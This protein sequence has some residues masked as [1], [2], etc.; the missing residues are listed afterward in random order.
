M[1]TRYI[2]LVAAAAEVKV[3]EANSKRVT[4][5]MWC[6]QADGAYMSDTAGGTSTNGILIFPYFPFE[7]RKAW[8]DDPTKAWY[9]YC[10]INN[11]VFIYEDIE[12]TPPKIPRKME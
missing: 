8:G 3:L 12:E 9:G 7:L 2:D 1:P 10:G 11:R 4:L 6:Q 5:S